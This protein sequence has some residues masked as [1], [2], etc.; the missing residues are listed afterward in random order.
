MVYYKRRCNEK[1]IHVGWCTHVRRME[2]GTVGKFRDASEALA[3]GYRVC[4]CCES[5]M[6]KYG[7]LP[8]PK[9][10][11]QARTVTSFV[12]SCGEQLRMAF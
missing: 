12:P 10:P 5:E 3:K 11:V 9:R 7:L 8:L 2:R 4:L 1:V 6:R